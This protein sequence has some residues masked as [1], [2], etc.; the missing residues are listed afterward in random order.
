MAEFNVLKPFEDIH[1]NEVY[2]VN[3][4]IELTDERFEEVTANLEAFGGGFIEVV[5]VV[6]EPSDT[7]DTT[8]DAVDTAD[9][10]KP[11]A[12]SKK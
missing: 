8:A 1:T 11:K 7:S 9:A 4:V 12:K 2:A 6:E 5:E 3:Q 10:E